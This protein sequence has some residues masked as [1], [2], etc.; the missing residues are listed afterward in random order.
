MYQEIE[1]DGT[2]NSQGNG[3]GTN[4]GGDHTVPVDPGT[5]VSPVVTDG[6]GASVVSLVPDGQG[7]RFAAQ[8][9]IIGKE[10]KG[11]G[12]SQ[13]HREME[14]RVRLRYEAICTF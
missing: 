2:G 14:Q 5:N 12:N 8:A 1:G 3:Q 7:T 6:G 13:N 11:K 10:E 4:E 9:E